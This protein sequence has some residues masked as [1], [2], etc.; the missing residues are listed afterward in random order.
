VKGVTSTP[1]RAALTVGAAAAASAAAALPLR[2][3]YSS[4]GSLKL[5]DEVLDMVSVYAP[6]LLAQGAEQLKGRCL[7]LMLKTPA[8]NPS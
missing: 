7:L 4:V 8:D 3:S 1:T 2:A 6:L 5:D